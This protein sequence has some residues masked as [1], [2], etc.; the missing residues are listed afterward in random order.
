VKSVDLQRF[1]LASE[2][3]FVYNGVKMSP[4]T[5][6]MTTREAAEYLGVSRQTVR[7]YHERGDLPGY[8][9]SPG[10]TSTLRFPRADVAA[11][12]HRSQRSH[13]EA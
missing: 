12:L 6:F 2:H 8:K 3:L 13:N 4:N 9:L 7:R 1:S 5:P 11:F 10:P